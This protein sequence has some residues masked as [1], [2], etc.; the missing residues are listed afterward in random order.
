LHAHIDHGVLVEDGG[1]DFGDFGTVNLQVDR[2]ALAVDDFAVGFQ[3]GG[4]IA[5]ELKLDELMLAELVDD[6][7][8]WAVVNKLAVSND[9][10]AFAQGLHVAHVMAREQDGDAAALIVF[11]EALLDRDLSDDVKTDRRFVEEK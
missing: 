5:V 9:E 4:K 7:G 1:Q 8:Q 3:A 6:A 10:H 11:A 2:W